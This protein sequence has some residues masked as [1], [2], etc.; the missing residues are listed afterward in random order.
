MA[1]T[2]SPPCAYPCACSA[3]ACPEASRSWLLSASCRNASSKHYCTV[4]LMADEYGDV[5]RFDYDVTR[6]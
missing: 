3:G 6:R 1:F 2:N 4:H 5:H